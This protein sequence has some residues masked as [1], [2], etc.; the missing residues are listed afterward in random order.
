[1]KKLL[2][3]L[4]VSIAG[5]NSLFSQQYMY[6]LVWNSFS[7]NSSV[8]T[9]EMILTLQ[10][11]FIDFDHDNMPSFSALIEIPSRGEIKLSNTSYQS[12]ALNSE[13]ISQANKL[14]NVKSGFQ[15]T[16]KSIKAGTKHYASILIPGV[17][18]Q[19][20]TY[21]KITQVSFELNLAPLKRDSPLKP[22][23]T[24]SSESGIKIEEGKWFKF[25]ITETG[26]QK[27]A[28]ETLLKHGIISSSTPSNQIK[29]YG[30]SGKMLPYLSGDERHPS[31]EE[32]SIK[33]NDGND[34]SF[35]SGDHLMFYAEAG[36]LPYY[37]T[38]STSLLNLPQYYS[39]SNFVFITINSSDPKRIRTLD[40]SG[41]SSS[42][43]LTSHDFFYHHEND[44][45]NFIK[46]GRIWVG[47]DFQTANP[48]KFSVESPSQGN[49]MLKVNACARSTVSTDNKIS[50][51]INGDT[52]TT[53]T[54]PIVSSV[55]YND[56][57]KFGGDV[58]TFTSDKE[59]NDIEFYYHNSDPGAL[60]WLDYFTLNYHNPLTLTA[61][62]YEHLFNK[63]ATETPGIYEYTLASEVPDPIIWDVSS[64]DEVSEIIAL[65]NG[66]TLTFKANSNNSS[67]FIAFSSSHCYSP[68]FIKALEAQQLN[69]ADV[70]EMLIVSH[71][72][73]I[74]EAQRLA[75]FHSTEDNL[76]TRVVNVEHIYN[77]KSSGR[78]EAGAIRD[79][80]KYL[81]E[82]PSS[83]DSLKYVFLFGSGSYDP[84]NRIDN[85]KD[86]I[87]TYQ[88]ENSVKLTSSYVTD[89]FYG[90]L[91]DHEGSFSFGD[92]LDLSVGRAPI[93][94]LEEAK[95]T[96]DKIFDYYG[97][98]SAVQDNGDSYS[99]KGS[100][101]NNLMFIADDGDA[102]EHMK[103][104]EILSAIADTSLENFNI[105][106]I[107]VDAFIKEKE[108]SGTT[109]KGVNEAIKRQ[110][111][112]GAIIVNYTG[113]G[114]EFG[115]GSERFLDIPDIVSLKN[116][117]KLPLLMTATCEFSRFD[118]PA[119]KSAGEY[120]F[121]QQE[122]GAVA[123]FTTVRLVFSIPNFNLNKNFYKVLKE[124]E[125]NENIRIGDLFRKTKIKNNAGTND[126][127]FTLLGD[128]ALRLALPKKAIAVDSIIAW[129]KFNVDTLKALT[130]ATIHGHIQDKNGAKM[131]GFNGTVEIKI[132]DKEVQRKTLD[133]ED[134]GAPFN[135]ITRSS[136][137]FKTLAA[138]NNGVFETETIIP[139][140]ILS[141]FDYSKI[142][143]F[144]TAENDDA[145]GSNK[146][147]IIGGQDTN[148]QEDIQGPEIQVFINDSNFAFGDR[149]SPYPYFIAKL[150]DESGINIS[151]ENIENNLVLTLN[152]SRDTEYVLNEKY[153]TDLNTYKKGSIVYQLEDIKEGSH[154]LE[155]KASDN[156]NN[157]SKFYTE[158]IIEEDAELALE[159]VLNYPNPFTT[160]TG[161]YFEQNQIKNSNIEVLI[162]I[163]TITGRIIKTIFADL[164]AN[165]K[166][167]G[168]IPWDGKDEYGDPI[169]RGVYLYRVKVS[170]ENG[171][172]A[173]QI[174]KL[175]ILK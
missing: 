115:W 146:E 162:Q 171:S 61:A 60:G 53:M 107:Y 13:E 98:Y 138:V 119:R 148:A 164:D 51:I 141:N 139:K 91:D 96:V 76:K 116:K 16:A 149:V 81:Y 93:K 29:V 7:E 129:G 147:Y 10:N 118:D 108:S 35:D 136:L 15:Y 72:L 21:K 154:T 122:G 117:T 57:V 174:E 167:I 33:V 55:Y 142:S 105:S 152:K 92:Q 59:I 82:N 155:F 38:T 70:P 78:K 64:Y 52:L 23:K 156:H 135:Y 69:Y 40:N 89:D 74:E 27:L 2:F 131:N 73:F 34:N 4:L 65:N 49:V 50:V 157:S 175:V 101:Q 111:S 11:G 45:L 84:K 160:N 163:Y 151:S 5:T 137:L 133:N 19:N 43:T 79:Y 87:P 62:S 125:N 1:M 134:T 143:L 83:G 58:V 46:S 159:H 106:K 75:D 126:R 68:V 144:A 48:L 130:Q 153:Q 110:I 140:S 80:I 32:M 104:A 150:N 173:E 67:N 166:L 85:N 47:E 103:Q 127:N 28:Y 44:L 124:E 99:S 12:E 22:K 26:P 121:L 128:P 77:H 102:N 9:P 161:F 3:T 54:I 39:D 145:K 123:L 6:E 169:G 14:V 120:M 25:A 172:K 37:D 94:S 42:K 109:V 165:K 90:S 18:F 168:P 31:L 8:N 132:F 112:N 30:N 36:N 170:A 88:S 158:F 86:L 24:N 100:W 20:G 41:L 97:F 17:I 95:T 71:P 66:G 114:G 56:Y 113:H 63:E